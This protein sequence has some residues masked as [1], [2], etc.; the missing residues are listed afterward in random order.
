MT[1]TRDNEVVD[2]DQAYNKTVSQIFMLIFFLGYWL[3]VW[4]FERVNYSTTPPEW[5]IGIIN[6]YPLFEI[7]S[8]FFLSVLELFS[9]RVLRHFIPLVTG[10]YLARVAISRFLESFYDLADQPAAKSLLNRLLARGIPSTSIGSLNHQNFKEQLKSNTQLHVGGPGYLYIESGAAAITEHNGRFK[11]VLSSGN[12]ALARFEYPVAVVDI[13]PQERDIPNIRMMTSGGIDLTVDVSVIFQIGRDGRQP[14]KQQQFPF[15]HDSARKAAYAET[16]IDGGNEIAWDTITMF[17]TA[18]ELRKLVAESQLDDL[19]HTRQSG[20]HPHPQLKRAMTQRL[21]PVLREI[22]VEILESQLGRFELPPPVVQ[23]NIN[24]WQNQWE[25][26]SG[27]IELVIDDEPL[28]QIADSRSIALS[29][30]AQTMAT[31]VKPTGIPR[32]RPDQKPINAYKVVEGMERYI[33][34]YAGDSPL[35]RNQLDAVSYLKQQLLIEYGLQ[36]GEVN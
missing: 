6:R 5:W 10:L 24:Y 29:D 7:I 8:R 11:R 30:L 17:A 4:Q 21:K 16:I 31:T 15:D 12:H 34:M 23:K 35:A 25:N 13:R 22:G 19:I 33:L 9:P 27:E 20:I 28:G 36:Q 3:Y 1:D 32:N 26:Q 18:A 14:S 2:T